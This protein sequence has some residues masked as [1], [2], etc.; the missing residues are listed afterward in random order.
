VFGG[1]AVITV[2]R[3]LVTLARRDS[4][5]AFPTRVSA[6]AGSSAT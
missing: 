4:A 2:D 1:P 6:A 5:D 3:N